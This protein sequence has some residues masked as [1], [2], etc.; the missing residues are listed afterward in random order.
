MKWRGQST[1]RAKFNNRYP[2]VV[3]TSGSFNDEL[4]QFDNYQ[5]AIVYA[6]ALRLSGNKPN[7]WRWDTLK[8]QWNTYII[9]NGEKNEQS[10]CN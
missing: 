9:S 5:E 6:T 1:E 7:L 4:E 8:Q 10:S 3:F 2:Y